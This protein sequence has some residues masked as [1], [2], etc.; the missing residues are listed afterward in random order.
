MAKVVLKLENVIF[1]YN[2]PCLKLLSNKI[3]DNLSYK[4]WGSLCSNGCG[5]HVSNEIVNN[6]HKDENVCG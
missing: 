1:L 4:S 6:V 2:A 3:C 5:Y